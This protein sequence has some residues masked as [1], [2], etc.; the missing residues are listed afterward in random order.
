MSPDP[1]IAQLDQRLAQMR[2]TARLAAAF[3]KG[4]IEEGID[5][6]MAVQITAIYAVTINQPA[7]EEDDP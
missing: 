7:A 5:T 3:C 2:E 1:Y 6:S 4:L